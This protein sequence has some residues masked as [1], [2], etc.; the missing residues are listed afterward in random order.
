VL[1]AMGV[2]FHLGVDVDAAKGRE[3]V[4]DYDAVFLGTGAYTPVDGRLPGQD[5][6]GVLPAL[7]FLV[8]NARRLLGKPH[9]DDPAFDLAGKRVLVLGGG[10]TAMD[11]VRSSLRLG[12]AEVTCAYRRGESDM[13]GSR[14]EVKN[15]REE[16]VRFVFNRQPLA[17]EA[18]LRVDGSQQVNGVRLVETRAAA[19]RSGA[20]EHVPGS[21]H[22]LAADVVI[23][24]FGF[25]ASPAPWWAEFGVELNAEGRVR[26]DGL[27]G[28]TGH[29]KVFAGGDNVRGADLVVTA[30]HDGREA[31]LAI[32]RMLLAE[33]T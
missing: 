12:A 8:A 30:V 11:C 19:G 17:I 24:A 3:L 15:A 6:P 21:E 10:D 13:P 2:R 27:P 18:G 1:E 29:A 25:R 14:R 31:G 7:P 9:R 16:G 28:R 20:T 5:L 33:A 32:A 22:V 26:T 4:R 23:L